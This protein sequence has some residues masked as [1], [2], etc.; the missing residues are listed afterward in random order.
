MNLRTLLVFLS[1]ACSPLLNGMQQ[2]PAQQQ[3][4]TWIIRSH[5]ILTTLQRY[6]CNFEE[7]F[8]NFLYSQNPDRTNYTLGILKFSQNA[9]TDY[10]ESIKQAYE[11]HL[12]S[13]TNRTLL[14]AQVL[15]NQKFNLIQQ[16]GIGVFTPSNQTQTEALRQLD[17]KIANTQKNQ[18]AIINIPAEG[19]DRET[20]LKELYKLLINMAHENHAVNCAELKIPFDDF[21]KMPSINVVITFNADNNTLS[22]MPKI[23]NHEPTFLNWKTLNTPQNI[24]AQTTLS[25]KAKNLFCNKGFLWLMA[26]STMGAA[27]TYAYFNHWLAEDNQ[28]EI[29]RSM[30]DL[31]LQYGTNNT[32]EILNQTGINQTDTRNYIWSNFETLWNGIPYFNTTDLLR[33]NITDTVEEANDDDNQT[34]TG[35]LP[36]TI[37]MTAEDNDT[38]DPDEHWYEFEL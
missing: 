36:I 34:S 28:Q 6:G 35:Y 14:K 4:P 13:I 21:L 2:Q 5:D 9:V 3:N 15:N 1:I 19:I 25:Q 31:I 23:F 10:Q 8:N 12:E 22:I 33:S 20:I 11:A 37:N 32:Q 24:I 27:A 7:T 16:L 18:A 30:E 38:I 29:N 17:A 26:V